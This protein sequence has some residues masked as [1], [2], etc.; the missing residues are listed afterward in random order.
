VIAWEDIAAVAMLPFR[1]IQWAL[2]NG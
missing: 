1:L 2:A